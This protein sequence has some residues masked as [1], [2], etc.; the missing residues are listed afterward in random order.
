MNLEVNLPNMNFLFKE[1]MLLVFS[2][3]AMFQMI[4]SYFRTVLENTISNG[5][6]IT[7]DFFSL[8]IDFNLKYKKIYRFN[9]DAFHTR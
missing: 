7:F 5:D 9:W 2:L 3:M 6:Y 8:K 1:F 4:T